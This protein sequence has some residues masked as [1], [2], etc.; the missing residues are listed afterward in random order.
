MVR[1]HRGANSL[2]S[3]CNKKTEI[4][5]K[6]KILKLYLR[7]FRQKHFAT[8]KPD[9]FAYFIHRLFILS[10][11]YWLW[12][13]V[14]LSYA[15]LADRC[16]VAVEV[17]NL[18]WI[19]SPL[20]RRPISCPETS[21]RNYATIR[22]VKSQK[23]ADLMYFSAEAQNHAEYPVQ[24]SFCWHKSLV[25]HLVG[26]WLGCSRISCKSVGNCTEPFTD[27]PASMA[28]PS[29]QWLEVHVSP[30]RHGMSYPTTSHVGALLYKDENKCRPVPDCSLAI[31]MSTDSARSSTRHSVQKSVSVRVWGF[32]GN[33]K[34]T[35][36]QATKAQR[37]S[38]GI[39][40]AL[41]LTSAL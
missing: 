15:F 40:L 14:S 35:L 27:P 10:D 37:R 31:H 34:F 26:W 36:E 11:N 12:F 4:W 6:C 17:T 20:K 39:A 41:S 28:L 32:T 21:L 1:T 13:P 22:C 2:P 18:S 5:R 33:V 8:A 9:N 29:V 19:S 7:T 25:P 24:L 30:T 16:W 3:L 38:G 23:I